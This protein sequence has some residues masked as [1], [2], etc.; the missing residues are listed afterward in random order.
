MHGLAQAATWA[1][2]FVG[3]FMLATGSVTLM[4]RD[5]AIPW[6]RPRRQWKREGWAEVLFGL[7]VMVETVP[8]LVNGSPDLVFGLSIAALVP[9]AGAILLRMRA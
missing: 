5:V 2:L 4:R 8:R 7:F 9:L 6:L 3:V 1:A